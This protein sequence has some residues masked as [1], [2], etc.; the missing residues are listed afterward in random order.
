VFVDATVSGS[1]GLARAGQLV[2][3]A[4]GPHQVR[5]LLAP[6]FGVLGRATAW[7][8]RPATAPGWE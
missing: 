7:W 2:V 5:D 3:L 8:A 1:E 4:S 6:A